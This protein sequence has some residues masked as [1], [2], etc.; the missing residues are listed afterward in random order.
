MIRLQRRWLLRL[1]IPVVAALG[2]LVWAMGRTGNVVTIENVSGQSIPLLQITRGGETKSFK[3]VPPG[4]SVAAMTTVSGA[5][6]VDGKLAD[7]TLL[8]SRFGEAEA[9]VDL[10]LLPGGQLTYRKRG[11]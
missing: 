6:S 2:I 11:E 5:F 1:A 9:R 4:K 8:R 3:D 7:G 10:V